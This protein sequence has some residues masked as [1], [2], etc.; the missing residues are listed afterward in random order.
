MKDGIAFPVDWLKLIFN[1]TFPY[2]FVHM[3][4]A[5]YLTTA[6]VVMAVG[7]RLILAG[8]YEDQARLMLK[9]GLGLALFLAPAQIFAGDEHG[10]ATAEYQPAKLAAIE[11]HWDGAEVPGAGALC[12]AE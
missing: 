7:A 5:A 8:R 3:V 9:M 4:I 6:I 11:A 1:P 12:L 2:R 10:L